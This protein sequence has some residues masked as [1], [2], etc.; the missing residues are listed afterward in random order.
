MVQYLYNLILQ[1]R[2]HCQTNEFPIKLPLF[3]LCEFPARLPFICTLISNTYL[4][5][6]IICVPSLYG[7]CRKVQNAFSV[8]HQKTWCFFFPPMG[9]AAVS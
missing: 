1:S 9:Q 7:W 3:S 4:R 5:C 2:C 8:Q 6:R